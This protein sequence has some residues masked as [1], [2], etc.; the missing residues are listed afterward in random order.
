MTTR[1]VVIGGDAA[2][3]S[4]A[5]QAVRSAAS[6]G[7]SV[8]VTVLEAT[9]HTSYSAC[10]LPY[11]IS[12]EVGTQD[13]LVARTPDQHRAMGLD[14]RTGAEVVRV[15]TTARTVRYRS[16]GSE[17]SL[18]YD[19]LVI[20]TGARPVTPEWA[21]ADGALKPGLGVVKTL[22]DG[23]FWLDQL[24]AGSLRRVVI[25]GGGYV[26]I[27]MAEA[28]L[29]RG[30]QV[31]LVARSRL[32]SMLEPALSA[33][34]ADTLKAAGV[35]V[36]LG[37]AVD[38]VEHDAQGRLIAVC[39]G[40]NR[41][42]ADHLVVALGATPATEF[43]TGSGIPLSARGALRPDPSGRVIPGVWAG[44][45]C[46]EVRHRLTDSW[47][48]LPL[49]T[50]ANK[51]GRAIGEN[52]GGGELTFPGA[53]GTAITR[54]AAPGGYLEAAATGL[55]LAQAVSAGFDAIEVVTQGTTASGY[56]PDAVPITISLI[57]D[58]RTGRLVGGQIVG[59][60]GAAKRIDVVAMALWTELTALDL[61]WADLAYAP[62]F[63]TAWEIVS[64]ASR[65]LAERLG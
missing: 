61:A 18:D 43:L 52:L 10:G 8:A 24:G 16:A 40:A 46:C 32:L 33:Q 45:D 63:A 41:I 58:R 20:A 23:S 21:R 47:S 34:L 53:L 29:A 65:R 13:E 31:T 26:G 44:G 42:D 37:S 57:G 27:E 15:D 7:R 56:H 60:R 30:H 49:G 14:L 1:I 36:V 6:H 4:A 55:N 5:H 64:L 2:G 3:M 48:F 19:E 35:E 12:G 39:A 25:A 28:A 62:P 9:V 59:G 51:M 50:H 17:Q 38:G 11:W 54:F 22:D